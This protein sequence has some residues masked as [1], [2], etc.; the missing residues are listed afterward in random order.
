MRKEEKISAIIQARITSTRLP[1]KVLMKISGK[2]MLWHIISRLSCSK[3]ISQII[4][5]IP[6]TK[7]N[8]LLEEFAKKEKIRYCRGSEE[9]VLARYYETAKKFKAS[10][11]IRITAD[12][13]LIDPEVLDKV[14]EEHLKSGADYTANILK[15][16]YPKGLEVE[17]MTFQALKKSYQEAKAAPERE[18]VTLYIRQHPEKF[19]R[20]NV[21]NSKDLSSF[22]WTVDEKEDLEFVR[23]IYKRLY[24]S[25]R[26]FLME[27]I[28][29]LL[30]KE[31]QLLE[32][33]K[34]IKRKPI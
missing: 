21:E 16:T 8:N 22:R 3:K 12:C 6:D 27:E 15:R 20:V 30:E 5:A 23:E 1:G 31:P 33:N 34:N 10:V 29:E 25:S 4:L 17:I 32:I 11:I 26:I 14:I 9:D 2:P 13:A 28:V 19:K 7:E 18:H 24:Q